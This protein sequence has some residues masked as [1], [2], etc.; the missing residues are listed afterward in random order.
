MTGG[1]RRDIGP[2]YP[3]L[4]LIVV[5]IYFANST[6][7]YIA[8]VVNLLARH[9]AAPTKH[10]WT[11]GKQILR[12]LNST[13]DLGLYFQKTQ[14]SSLVGYTDTGY[15]SDPHKA[16]SQKGFIFLHGGMTISWKSSK[17]ILLATSK[18]HYKIIALYEASRGCVWLRRMINHV[19]NHVEL[20]P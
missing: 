10:H 1:G 17:Q 15:M 13:K 18:N 16:R 3:Y 9:S 12:Y 7:P 5:L 2:K 11:R 20:V 14:D 6:R 19:S 8:F 4:S